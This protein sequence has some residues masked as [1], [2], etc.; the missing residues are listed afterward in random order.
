MLQDDTQPEKNAKLTKQGILTNGVD[1]TDGTDETFPAESSRHTSDAISASSTRHSTPTHKPL[2]RTQSDATSV[3]PKLPSSHRRFSATDGE[4]LALRARSCSFSEIIQSIF[5]SSLDRPG[6]QLSERCTSPLSV[7]SHS[8][9][10]DST[11]LEKEVWPEMGTDLDAINASRDRKGDH[12]PTAKPPSLSSGSQMAY[13]SLESTQSSSDADQHSKALPGNTYEFHGSLVRM[14]KVHRR[15]DSEVMPSPPA[16][17]RWLRGRSKSALHTLPKHVRSFSAR[18]LPRAPVESSTAVPLG[19]TSEYL[20]TADL[21]NSRY[22]NMTKDLLDES[23][24]YDKIDFCSE[25]EGH[26]ATLDFAAL[27]FLREGGR[28]ATK[29]ALASNEEECVYAKVDI[30][31]MEVA[32][33]LADQRRRERELRSQSQTSSVER[34][35]QRRHTSDFNTLQARGSDMH[36]RLRAWSS[37]G[38]GDKEGKTFTE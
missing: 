24:I 21:A 14:R 33:Q 6:S 9:S 20:N 18:P 12:L 28:P 29:P 13:F 16:A 15:T 4:E 38:L 35:H 19:P 27:Q 25:L 34:E 37:V 8:I 22:I 5:V 31:A 10:D 26:Y 17:P 2:D 36:R 32:R 3:H 23:K 11:Q 7:H 30:V 1:E